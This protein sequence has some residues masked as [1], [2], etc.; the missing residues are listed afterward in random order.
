MIKYPTERIIILQCLVSTIFFKCYWALKFEIHEFIYVYW[1]KC[2]YNR[3]TIGKKIHR[4]SYIYWTHWSN[5]NRIAHHWQMKNITSFVLGWVFGPHNT[6]I[7]RLTKSTS[8]SNSDFFYLYQIRYVAFSL[9]LE[10]MKSIATLINVHR[11]QLAEL[12][13]ELQR[14]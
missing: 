5:R 2:S 11:L 9:S 4:N 10:Q 12:R 14:N 6:H 1:T 8:N 3:V 7:N 13:N